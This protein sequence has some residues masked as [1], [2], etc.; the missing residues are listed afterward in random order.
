MRICG[1]S[2][3]ILLLSRL[4]NA[5]KGRHV[6]VVYCVQAQNFGGR[7]LSKGKN[8][9]NAYPNFEGSLQCNC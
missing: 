3:L 5:L 7:D 2:R 6:S 9:P 8:I 4:M 1:R